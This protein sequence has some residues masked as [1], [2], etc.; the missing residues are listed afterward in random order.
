MTNFTLIQR[1]RNKIKLKNLVSLEIAKSAKIVGCRFYV[2][3][4][5]NKIHIGNGTVLRNV[6]I[7][8]MGDNC[9]LFI[10]ESCMIG[11]KCYISIKESTILT[12]ENDCGLSRN[13]KIMTS[14]G[15]PIFKEQ[16]RINISKDI[17][18]GKH[19]WIADNA[20]ILKGVHIGNGSVI[21]MNATVTKD[22]PSNAVAV[23][24]PAKIVNEN[25]RWEDKI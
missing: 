23:G 14:D 19:V 13:V 15:H 1:L 17:S 9:Q 3:G 11:D 25:I 6:V 2:K 24:N 20:T 21:G 5:N 4:N 8:I 16:K 22:V 18:I 12:I 10:G 7:E